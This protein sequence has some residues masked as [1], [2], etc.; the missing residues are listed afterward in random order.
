[1]TDYGEFC[2]EMREYRKEARE[3]RQERTMKKS[4]EALAKAGVKYESRNNGYHFIIRTPRGVVNYYPTT[5]HYNGLF[6]GDGVKELIEKLNSIGYVK[7]G[8][9]S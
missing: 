3:R 9:D 8:K 2:R 7:D 5:E 6:S 4:L 1:M